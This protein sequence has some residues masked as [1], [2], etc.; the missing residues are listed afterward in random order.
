MVDFAG[1]EWSW[2]TFESIGGS[3]ISGERFVTNVKSLHF[4]SDK[5]FLFP[6]LKNDRN[7]ESPIVVDYD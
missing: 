3:F 6:W 1:P 5:D 2:L 7:F 4:K